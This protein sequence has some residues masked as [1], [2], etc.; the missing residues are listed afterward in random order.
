MIYEIAIVHSEFCR[1]LT[2]INSDIRIARVR[3]ESA[4]TRI[5]E[6]QARAFES[7]CLNCY[8][9]QQGKFNC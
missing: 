4:W 8:L 5:H 1:R 3:Y 7:L 2:V 9:Q 6:A